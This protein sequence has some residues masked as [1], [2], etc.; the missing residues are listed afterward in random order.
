LNAEPQPKVLVVDDISSNRVAM[1][2]LLD[3][4]DVDVVEASSGAEALAIAPGQTFAVALLDVQMPIMDG[5]EL[6]RRLRAMDEHRE[7]PI[8]FVSA[9]HR[10][11]RYVREGYA[12][13]AA[14]YLT[15]PLEAEVLRAR[16]RAFVDLF[17]QRE[18]LR[19][20][21]RDEAVERLAA[22]V[23]SERAARHEAELANA[24]K[25]EF[26]ALA[27]HEL[28]T[29]LTSILGWAVLVRSMPEGPQREHA[30]ETIEKNARAQ[31]R[32]IDDL[33]DMS[34]AMSGKL[35]IEP[36]PSNVD[37]AVAAAVAALAPVSDE[38]GV[39]VE[40]DARGGIVQ[41]DETRIKQVVTNLLTNAIKFTPRGGHVS[42]TARRRD[43]GVDIVVRDTG[44]GIAP[45]LLKRIF[46]PF[47]QADTSPSRV[48]GGLGL[49]LAIVKRIV[50]AH[51]GRVR[52]ESD[53]VGCG[54]A[55]TVSLPA[56]VSG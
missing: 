28:R 15:K 47:K 18:R 6:A 38:K 36:K 55:F 45:D 51:G 50:E 2:A 39:G 54:A 4:L 22:L 8:I 9:V 3:A 27:S 49:G 23:E 37:E 13:G 46:E 7:L 5:F 40:V 32:L 53:G 19:R 35:S 52:A 14:D 42:V 16:V 10:D 11:E 56:E 21:E 1:S 25:D 34:R 26:I 17:R 20:K 24:A 33:L 43:D 41:C 48:H 30:L 29:P 12:A 31:K 44:E